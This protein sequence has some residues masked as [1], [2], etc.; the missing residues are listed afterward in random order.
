MKDNILIVPDVHGRTFW[1]DVQKYE[2]CKIIFLG[3][4]FDPYDWEDI[5]WEDTIANFEEIIDFK[6]KHKDNVVLL[7]G[8]HDLSY[9]IG[10]SVCNC[11]R[12]VKYENDIEYLFKENISLFKLAHS[13]YV[14]GKQY[15][16]SHAGLSYNWFK[17][18]KDLVVINDV[19]NKK[20]DP[21]CF[22]NEHFKNGN[23]DPWFIDMLAE[24]SSFRGFFGSEFGSVV[25][26]DVREWV[27]SNI[28]PTDGYQIFGHS[29]LQNTGEAIIKEKFA[30]LDCRAAFI[31]THNNEIKKLSEYENSSI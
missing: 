6:L 16:F 7:L 8:N 9:I 21:V 31:L 1:K 22:V 2:D 20:Q 3:D 13:E 27:K 12:S 14:N 25:W 4:Y 29:Q 11:R 26:S 24:Y 18:H 28:E 23:P 17:Q 5:S 10:K 19:L 15:V 30:D